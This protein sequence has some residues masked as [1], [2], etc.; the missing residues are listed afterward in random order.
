MEKAMREIARKT[1]EK[2]EI[3]KIQKR[4]VNE[5]EKGKKLL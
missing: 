4:N 1:G 2:K 5:W 3:K